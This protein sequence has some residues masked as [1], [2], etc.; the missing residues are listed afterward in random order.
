MKK[1]ITWFRPDPNQPRKVFSNV[2]LKDLAS[3][4]K[5]ERIIHPIEVDSAGTIIVGERRW[6]AAKIAGLQELEEGKDFVINDRKMTPYE[7]LRRQIVENCHHSSLSGGATTMDAFDEARA[8]DSMLK[9]KGDDLAPGARRKENDR[10]ISQLSKELGI[11]QRTISDSLMLL[12]EPQFVEDAIVKKNIPK[13]LFREAR[14]IEDPKLRDTVKRKIASG[15]LKTSSE[16]THVKTIIKE[17]PSTARIQ[18][19]KAIDHQTKKSNEIC[20][21]IRK[22]CHL[23]A[24][25]PLSTLPAHRSFITQTVNDLETMLQKFLHS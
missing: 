16:V 3:T 20:T 25:N 9:L 12:E 22:L 10:G 4:F 17:S 24:E 13:S 19:S 21:T 6:R 2:E 23:I 8:F 14:S 5:T 11:P 18:L 1:P 7:R 15:E